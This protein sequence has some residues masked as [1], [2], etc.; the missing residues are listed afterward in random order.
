MKTKE[1]RSKSGGSRKKMERPKDWEG[2]CKSLV[3][4]RDRCLAELDR[5]RTENWMLRDD[6]DA[7][8]SGRIPQDLFENKKKYL[9]LA[10]ESSI[11]EVINELQR[12]VNDGKRRDSTIPGRRASRRNGRTQ[13]IARQGN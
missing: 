7:L 8:M 11:D 12:E 4:E 2:L 13:R 10:K 6:L 3:K 5:L 9:A 1:V